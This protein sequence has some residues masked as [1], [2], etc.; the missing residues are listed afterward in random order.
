MTTDV[1]GPHPRAAPVRSGPVR[2]VMVA[3]GIAAVL[4]GIVLMANPFAAARTL[5]LL[6]GLGLVVTGCLE[7]ALGWGTGHRGPALALGAVLVVGGVLA[8]AWPDVT[9]WTIAVVTGLSLVLHGIARTALAVAAR[10][11]VPGWGWLALAG[12]LNVVVGVLALSW[13]EATIVVL[14]VVL[15]LEVLLFGVLLLVA[16]VV[17]SSRSRV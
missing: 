7:I 9:L 10:S 17:G 14:S 8:A 6:I 2:T 16:A 4:V 15:G 1:T 13:P 11:Q 12:V 3:L 5:A